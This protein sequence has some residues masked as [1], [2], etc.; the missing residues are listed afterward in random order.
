MNAPH[1]LATPTRAPLGSS[2]PILPMARAAFWFAT[3]Y[4]S[5]LRRAAKPNKTPGLDDPGVSRVHVS[6]SIQHCVERDFLDR[7]RADLAASTRCVDLLS[8]FVSPN[9]SADY[10]PVFMALS[11]RSVTVRAYVRPRAE[12]PETL[13]PTYADAVRNLELRGVQVLCRPGM[14]EKV[15]AIDGR[16]LW[17]GSLNILS[18]NDSR[19]SMLRFACPELAIEILQDLGIDTGLD[20][21]SSASTESQDQA[22]GPDVSIPRCTVCGGP[23]QLFENA[24]IWVC[25]SSPRCPG[26]RSVG[27]VEIE[28]EAIP[29]PRPSPV[30]DLNCPIC[31]T[32]MVVKG[33]L[34]QKISCPMEGCGFELDPR[35]SAG[36]LR[37]LSRRQLV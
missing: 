4:Y 28:R 35:L 15:A 13:R 8:P 17:H 36:I 12:Q 16:I 37:I 26:I 3:G 10:Y 2:G 21:P 33:I 32:A 11:V 7:F 23:M 22:S 19:E 29:A 1:S 18:H 34:R 31:N 9:R 5:S 30:L 25:K 6:I 24:G 20:A 14:H 27:S